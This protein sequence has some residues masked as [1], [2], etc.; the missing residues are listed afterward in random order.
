VTGQRGVAEG[1]RAAVDE[2]ERLAGPDAEPRRRAGAELGLSRI[3]SIARATSDASSG[4][5]PATWLRSSRIPCSARSSSLRSTTWLAPTPVFRPYTGCRAARSRPVWQ[6]ARAAASARSPTATSASRRA[7]AVTAAQVSDAP[8][9]T[10][11]LVT[12]SPSGGADRG[13]AHSADNFA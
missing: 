2:P 10:T 11:V 4:P 5:V 3:T 8:L 12:A 13:A 7:T 6:A 1:C 9:T